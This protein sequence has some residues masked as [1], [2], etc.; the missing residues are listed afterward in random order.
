MIRL[1]A[2]LLW[3][4]LV[5]CWGW[6]VRAY[7]TGIPERQWDTMRTV[8]LMGYVPF[9]IAPLFLLTIARKRDL[10]VE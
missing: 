7:P 8:Q 10:P 6:S 1:L 5:V 4:A 2:G 3:V 9:C